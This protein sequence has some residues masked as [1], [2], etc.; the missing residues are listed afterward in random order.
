MQWLLV[1]A[2]VAC[3]KGD[4][5]APAPTPGGG[6]A[7][8]SV[9][10]SGRWTGR[11]QWSSPNCSDA[12][13]ADV[14]PFDVTIKAKGTAW[15]VVM[16]SPKDARL[17]ATN[18]VAD[19]NTCAVAVSYEVPLPKPRTAHVDL[20]LANGPDGPS[21]HARLEQFGLEKNT[22]NA[23][24]LASLEFATDDG[25]IPDVS[26]TQRAYVGTYQVGLVWGETNCPNS[27]LYPKHDLAYSIA[28]DERNQLVATG[29]DWT[30]DTVEVTARGLVVTA[31]RD[32]RELRQVFVQELTAGDT[33]VLGTVSFTVLDGDLVTCKREGTLRGTIT[34]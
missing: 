2:L 3:G 5:A 11:I 25:R 17:V 29:I 8:T 14:A 32:L 4:R 27:T 7:I 28:L 30:I 31:H 34:R 20:D 15:D 16:A 9:R 22:C 24:G 23:V 19:A 21:A 12:T 26:A 1:L 33:G 10:C 18:V 13:I 6:S